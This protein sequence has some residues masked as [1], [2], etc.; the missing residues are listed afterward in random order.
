MLHNYNYGEIFSLIL[1]SQTD[2]WGECTSVIK[3]LKFNDTQN[4]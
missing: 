3:A 2:L 1:W 4:F